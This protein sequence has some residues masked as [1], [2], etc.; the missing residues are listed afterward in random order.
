MSFCT[1]CGSLLPWALYEIRGELDGI[2]LSDAPAAIAELLSQLEGDT[3]P[4][5][6]TA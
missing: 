3:M 6:A 2:T 1:S 5:T 4:P